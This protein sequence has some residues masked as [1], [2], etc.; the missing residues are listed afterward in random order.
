ME[1]LDRL[2]TEHL[3]ERL[4]NPERLSALLSSLAAR[5]A[6]KAEGLNGRILALQKEMV[7]ADEK[8]ARL[9]RLIED[10]LTEID[11]VLKDRLTT[12][13]ANRDR[14]KAAL[15]RAREGS[16]RPIRIDPALIER[17]GRAMRENFTNGSIPFRKSYLHALI[18]S[19]EVGDNR[20]RIKGSKELLEK[21]VLA[22]QAGTP[23]GSQMGTKWRAGRDSN[24]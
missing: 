12:L 11:D 15:D 18:D 13:K 5:R 7:D 10:G 19:I 14:A 22:S 17:F 8:L 1:K 4:F 2:V 21:A 23:P 16:A 20:I 6:E 3:I 24:P 9:Y